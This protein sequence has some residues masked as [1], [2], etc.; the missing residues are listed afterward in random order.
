MGNTSFHKAPEIW[1]ELSIFFFIH[2]L[3]SILCHCRLDQICKKFQGSGA[4]KELDCRVI[5]NLGSKWF[6]MIVLVVY[7]QLLSLAFNTEPDFY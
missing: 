5:L 4:I 1:W 2:R 3:R 6:K 7:L